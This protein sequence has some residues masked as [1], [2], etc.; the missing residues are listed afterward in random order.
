MKVNSQ[1]AGADNG[2]DGLY[3]K[4]RF[5]SDDEPERRVWKV[6]TRTDTSRGEQLYQA[7]IEI[8][9]KNSADENDTWVTIRV[10]FEEFR[11][12]R[13]AR[14]MADTESRINV[15]G[16]LYQIGMV[17]SKF[18]IAKNMTAIDNFR[19]G[20]FEL[21]ISEIGLYSSTPKSTTKDEPAV[22]VVVDEDDDDKSKMEVQVLSKEQA[23]KRLPI[24]LKVLRPVSKLFFSEQR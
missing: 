10:P 23:S 20:Y 18:T 2:G 8:P 6:T 19:P 22:V 3:V 17:M 21:Q 13:G 24:L 7:M 11:L 5:T 9:K 12:V 14:L 16:G 1:F 4:C 15:T